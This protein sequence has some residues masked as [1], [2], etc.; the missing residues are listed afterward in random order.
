MPVKKMNFTRKNPQNNK[1]ENVGYMTLNDSSER[2]TLKFYGDIVGD[3]W[4]VW[5]DEDKCPEAVSKFFADLDNDK[6][7]DIYFNSGGGD[8]FAGIAIY[9]IIKRHSGSKTAYVDGLA[10]SIAS[11]ILCAADKIIINTGAQVMIHNPWTWGWGDAI[12]MRSIAER[13]DTA[14]E[15]ILDIYEKKKVDTVDRKAIS[16]AMD[17]ETWLTSSNIKEWFDFET[18]TT[19]NAIAACAS[20]YYGVYKNTPDN[21]HN[22]SKNLEK[23]KNDLLEDLYIYGT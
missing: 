8:V 5:T 21:I 16:Q 18:D 4:G 3:S 20:N 17:N 22:R 10:A 7:I 14:K 15:S 9:N 2:A 12:E 11:V 13:L 19:Q 1:F 6:P 23:Q